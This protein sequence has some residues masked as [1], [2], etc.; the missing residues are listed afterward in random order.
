MKNIKGIKENLRKMILKSYINISS[1]LKE[2]TGSSFIETAI[3][4]LSAV[5]IGALVLAGIYLLFSTII[6]PT[7]TERIQ[8]MFNYKGN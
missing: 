2:N 6:F 8:E 7:L 3:K 4:I 5:V 1:K